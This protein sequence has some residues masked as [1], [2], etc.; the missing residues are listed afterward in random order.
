MN[1]THRRRLA[2]VWV[3]F[4]GVMAYVTVADGITADV[5]DVLGLLTVALGLGLAY[6]YYAKPNGMLDFGRS[7]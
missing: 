4:A 6:V 1:E 3:A 5:G 7:E 2:A